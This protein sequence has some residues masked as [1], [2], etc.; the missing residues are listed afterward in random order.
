MILKGSQR[1]GP[2]QLAAHLLNDRDNDHVTVGEVRGFISQDLFGAMAE[3]VA[4]SRGT[5]C[6][7]PIFSLSLNPPKDAHVTKD[8]L[9]AAADKAGEA[10]ALGGQPRAVVFHEKGSRLHAHVVWSRIDAETM[11]AINL[12]F[13]KTRLRE[14]SKELFLEHGW[15]LPDGHKQNG[16][17][18]PLNFTLGE[19]QQAKRLDLDPREIKQIFQGAWARSDNLS[20]L[21][22]ALEEH[23]YYLARGDRRG[24]VA[25]GITGEVFSLARYAG[26]KTKDVTAKLKGAE[27]L[28]D[29]ETTRRDLKSRIS[30]QMLEFIADDK[31][32]KRK[33]EAPWVKELARLRDLHRTERQTL[34]SKQDERFAQESKERASRFRRGLGALLDLV[35]GKSAEIKKQNELEAVAA[36]KRDRAQREALFLAQVKER[37]HPQ[38]ILDS[39]QR[40]HRDSRT[41]LARHIAAIIARTRA[42]S[43]QHDRR[44][45]GP[46]I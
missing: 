7:Q 1:G 12:P 11:T 6:Q 35:S 21:R 31:E 20:S 23:G 5:K 45:S 16:H 10:L 36:L 30:R 32:A 13:Y 22:S 24:V 17:R 37:A 28:P 44:L 8:D 42:H 41:S 14:L 46:G 34:T 2:R 43:H 15:E 3:A 27:R 40:R 18:N 4:V 25:L 29:I 39:I 26:V 33:D 38:A 9:F 19:W